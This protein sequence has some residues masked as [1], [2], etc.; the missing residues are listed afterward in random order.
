MCVLNKLCSDVSDSSVGQEFN[1]NKS[2]TYIK[3]DVFQQK[4]T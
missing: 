3:Y 4:H 1:V 2:T